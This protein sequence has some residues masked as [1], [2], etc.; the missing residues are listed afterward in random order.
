MS[1]DGLCL[2]RPFLGLDWGIAGGLYAGTRLVRAA[3]DFVNG[4]MGARA[5][6]IVG[7]DREERSGC[8]GTWQLCPE[9]VSPGARLGWR[10]STALLAVETWHWCHSEAITFGFGST[11]HPRWVQFTILASQ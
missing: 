9:H 6:A 1:L 8:V 11:S 10:Y 5:G 3:T 2:E 4:D 7:L